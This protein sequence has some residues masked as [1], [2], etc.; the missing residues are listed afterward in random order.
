[1]AFRIALTALSLALAATAARADADLFINEVDADQVGTDAAEF[2]ELYN[3]GGGLS[4]DGWFLVLYNGSAANDTEYNTFDLSGRTVPADGYFVVGAAT[5]PDVDFTPSNFPATNAIQN[6]ADGVALIFDTTGSYTP[7]DFS[8]TEATFL[9]A[10]TVRV[11]ALVYG[12]DDADDAALIAALTPGQP[13]VDEAASG[14]NGSESMQRLPDGGTALATGNHA[15]KGPTPGAANAPVPQWSHLGCA[16]AGVAGLPKLAGQGKLVKGTSGALVLSD[17]APN[18]SMVLLI[19]LASIPTPFKGGTLKAVPVLLS[20]SLPTG[21]TGGFTLPWVDWPL[22]VGGIDLYFQVAIADTAAVHNVSL[23][24]ALK[25]TSQAGLPLA[26]PVPAALIQDVLD[27]LAALTAVVQANL[28][29]P[30]GG[31]TVLTH[32]RNQTFPLYATTL[33]TELT[34]RDQ[35]AILPYVTLGSKLGMEGMLDALN[36]LSDPELNEQVLVNPNLQLLVDAFTASQAGLQAQLTAQTDGNGNLISGA[37]I[38][39]AAW[40]ILNEVV[41]CIPGLSKLIEKVLGLAHDR[42]HASPGL[43]SNPSG[44]V[45]DMLGIAATHAQTYLDGLSSPTGGRDMLEHARDVTYPA[46]YAQIDTELAQLSLTGLQPIV[47]QVASETTAELNTL[48]LMTDPQLNDLV[49]ASDVDVAMAQAML[50]ANAGQLAQVA[51]E[52]DNVAGNL[53]PGSVMA[54]AV[55]FDIDSIIDCLPDGLRKLIRAI[56]RILGGALSAPSVDALEALDILDDLSDVVIAADGSPTRGRVV[57][58]FMQVDSLPR[59]FALMDAKLPAA[60]PELSPFNTFGQ[61]ATVNAVQ[62]ALNT[63]SDPVLNQLVY[64]DPHTLSVAQDFKFGTGGNPPA[65]EFAQV[66]EADWDYL[67]DIISC[68]L[69][70]WWSWGIQLVHWAIH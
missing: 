7:V 9:L 57:L 36:T 48:L 45:S 66:E 51:A 55:R 53:A 32:I 1:M 62:D 20:L 58:T 15:V 34:L 28:A 2:I 6:G 49:Y 65:S 61:A 54:N 46:Y 23:S 26:S 69:N 25:G 68:I 35:A 50:A 27:E 17:A 33:K 37:S 11:D 43:N 52:T 41:G 4:L 5:V 70:K 19:S 18:S 12:T 14:L 24:N 21:P 47:A 59:T 13:Q 3:P 67:V 38:G 60:A 40:T 29:A 64:D 63:L 39:G 42:A 16:L 8:G 31:R 44:Q 10:G 30:D 56:Q 22:D